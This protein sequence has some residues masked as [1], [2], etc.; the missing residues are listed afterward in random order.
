M[1][2]YLVT[3]TESICGLEFDSDC[4]VP[5]TSEKLPD[6]L[7]RFANNWREDSEAEVTDVSYREIPEDHFNFLKDNHY[8]HVPPFA[9]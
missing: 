2:Y 8:L 5:S 4:L 7:E 6:K 1:T 3:V 9:H